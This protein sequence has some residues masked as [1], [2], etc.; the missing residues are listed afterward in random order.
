VL[1]KNAIAIRVLCFPVVQQCFWKNSEA[2][3][4]KNLLDNI[5]ILLLIKFFAS[6]QERI[7]SLE[8][9]H[10]YHSCVDQLNWDI[11]VRSP[12]TLPVFLGLDKSWRR[13]D[14]IGLVTHIGF[15][16]STGY[17]LIR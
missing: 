9:S 3:G 2:L 5:P 15:Q 10:L 4:L 11:L 13:V 6:K 12:E 1:K 16:Y 17:P 8:E 14:S 7:F